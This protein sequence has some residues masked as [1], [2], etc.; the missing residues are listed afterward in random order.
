[1]ID[2][3]KLGERA[4]ERGYR[5]VK[6]KGRVVGKHDWGRYGLVDAKTGHQVFGFGKRGVTATLGEIDRF[7]AGGDSVVFEKSL[8]ESKR[9]KRPLLPPFLS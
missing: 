9:R 4:S 8:R 5:L 6:G 2:P 3:A 7:L 1:M